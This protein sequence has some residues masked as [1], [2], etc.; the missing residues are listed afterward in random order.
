[1]RL[2]EEEKYWRLCSRDKHLQEGDKNSKFFHVSATSRRKK[3]MILGMEDAEGVWQTGTEKVEG[4]VLDYFTNIFSAHEGLTCMFRSAEERKA[5]SGIK[6]ARDCPG[7]SRILFADDTMVFCRANEDE[8]RELMII[9]G[10]YELASGQ[11][12]NVGKSSVS[13]EPQ[14]SL[15]IRVRLVQILGMQEVQDQ[16]K[17]LGLPSHIGRI[18]KEVF[19]FLV[20]KVEERIK[21]WKRKLLSQVGRG[22]MVKSVAIAIPHFVMKCFKLPYETIDVLNNHMTKFFWASSDK[23]RGIHWQSWDKLCED[24]LEGGLGFK[25][26]ECMNLALLAKQG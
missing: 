21:G 12:V 11:K 2:R 16:G 15:D 26:L 20:A 1:M 18:K 8:G 25:D 3:N 22:V 17:Y 5:L 4:I 7:I 19:A 23:E 10:D 14:V 13:F 9:L 6:I 24:K